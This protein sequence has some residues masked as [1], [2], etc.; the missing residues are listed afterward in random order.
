[1]GEMF[2]SPAMG[3]F[4]GMVIVFAIFAMFGFARN[5]LS[6]AGFANWM[7]FASTVGIIAIPVA[8][9]MIAGELDI[10]TGAV[11]PASAMMLGIS[12]NHYDVPMWLGIIMTLTMAA[13]VGLVNGLLVTRTQVPSFIVTLATLFAVGGLTL[14][15]SDFLINNT[16]VSMQSPDWAKALFGT[17]YFGFRSA[18]YWWLALIVVFWFFLHKS[19]WGNWVFAVGGDPES[20]RNAGIP[21]NKLKIWLFILCSV[22]TALAGMCQVIQFNSAQSATFFNM[23]FFTIIASVVG[24]VLLNG[25]FGSVAGVVFGTMTL[26]IV[27]QG[28]NYTDID[29]NLSLLII[30]VMLLIAVLMNGTFQ[31]LATSWSSG[32]KED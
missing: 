17:R 5:F 20:A 29:R 22:C 1:M 2:R 19:P 21:V 3:A 15:L 32:K 30:G 13:S 28:I 14:A 23:I 8:F 9:L 25:G 27:Q 31:R 16:N 4:V 6:I 12:V 26:G 10:S 11:L 24:G 18:V 7:N